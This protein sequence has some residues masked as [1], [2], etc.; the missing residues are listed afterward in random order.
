MKYFALFSV[1][2]VILYLAGFI[3]KKN[4]DAFFMDREFTTAIKGI[5]ILTVVWAHAGASL[6]VE[7]I[8][9][10]AGVGVAL[11]LVCSG[12]GLELSYQKNG[13]KGFWKKRFTK[14]CIPFWVVELIG[15]FITHQFEIKKYLLDAVFI[16]PATG[17]G[18]FM[19]YIV[20]CYVL[21][22]GVKL[23][24]GNT[25]ENE[26][27]L[28]IT[29]FAIWFVI[30]S[31]FFANLDMPFLK[32][33]Q[34]LSFPLGVMIAKNKDKI[35]GFIS[36]RKTPFLVFG[37]G[38]LAGVLFMGITQFPA[39][40][41]LPFVLSNAMAL[42][43]VLPLAVAVICFV[44]VFKR[45]LDNRMLIGA[46]VISYEIYLVHVFTLKMIEDSSQWFVVFIVVTFVLAKLLHRILESSTGI[47]N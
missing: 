32:A 43:T 18:W 34:M 28:L 7:G 10:I 1:I 5:A 13:L 6:G 37:G 20:I 11:F 46:G 15:L 47:L 2:L 27:W 22:F 23:L 33:R 25:G 30:D 44:D 26:V 12:Y 42:F 16:S 17:Y 29:A 21:F 38:V 31:C 45:L 41:S 8:Q 40:K 35:E 39:V 36:G 4:K 3:K 14:V 19:Q 24:S 9:F